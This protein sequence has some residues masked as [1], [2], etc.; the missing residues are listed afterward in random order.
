L[1]RTADAIVDSDSAEIVAISPENLE[2][3]LLEEPKV[4]LGFLKEMAL[5]LKHSNLQ[6]AH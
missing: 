3:L 4:A 6:Q 5:R 2:T 1:A